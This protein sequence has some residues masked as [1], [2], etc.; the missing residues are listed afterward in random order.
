M[1]HGWQRSVRQRRPTVSVPSTNAHRLPAPIAAYTAPAG[2]DRGAPGT[3]WAVQGSGRSRQALLADRNTDRSTSPAGS[4]GPPSMAWPPCGP[5]DVRCHPRGTWETGYAGPSSSRSGKPVAEVRKSYGPARSGSGAGP[6]PS[7]PTSFR[8]SWSGARPSR[9][10]P[11][12]RGQETGRGKPYRTF[13]LRR[14]VAALPGVRC[15]RA[16]AP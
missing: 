15:G 6:G 5:A 13:R 4:P 2:P 11:A 8:S 12:A 1:S 9:P 16:H 3:V 7:G 10:E 14:L